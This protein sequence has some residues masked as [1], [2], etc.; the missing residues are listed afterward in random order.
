[1]ATSSHTPLQEWHLIDANNKVLGRLA[2]HIAGL[3]IGKHRSDF[4]PNKVLPVFVVV[5]NS[6]TVHLTGRKE[7]QKMYRRYSGYPG[8]LRERTAREVRRLDSRRLIEEAVF[9]MLPKNSLRNERMKHLKVYPTAEHPHL[10]QLTP[11]KE[12]TI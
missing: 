11:K 3:L 8:G 6:N 4:A 2:T 1:M 12:E 10:P 9:G 5:T 7:E